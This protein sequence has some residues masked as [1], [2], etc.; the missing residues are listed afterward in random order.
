MKM[1]LEGIKVLD[2]SQVAAVPICAR[3]LADFG[4]DVI[5]IE[6]PV[7]GDSWRVFQA[8][9]ELPGQRAGI[10][11]DINYT[12]EN[13]NRNK[14][15]IALDLSRKAGQEVLYKMVEKS[16][17]LVTNFRPFELEKYGLEY[18]ILR[19][20]NPRLVFGS[21]SA[22]GKLGAEKN[23]PGY[24]STIYWSRAGLPYLLSR[25][26]MPFPEYRVTIGDVEVGVLLAFGVMMA[27]YHRE[28]TGIGQE[29]DTSL[30]HAGI[31]Q[32]AWDIA[33]YLATGIDARDDDE[34]REKCG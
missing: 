19:K 16:D 20:I 9:P 8:V 27:L 14:R 31:Y 22:V 10:P 28:R 25:K 23:L 26:G 15:S 11:S 30:F 17:V 21:I 32:M 12:W 18:S 24:D 4:A 29:V 34:V 33:A 7:R 5:H 2:V 1:A 6:H 13:A 3:H